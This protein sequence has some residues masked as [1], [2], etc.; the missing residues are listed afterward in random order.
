V[1]SENGA[2][3]SHRMIDLHV[4]EIKSE[5]RRNFLD[6]VWRQKICKSRSRM[7]LAREGLISLDATPVSVLQLLNAF[8]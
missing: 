6:F 4:C 8:M 5:S 3:V 1:D 7:L 2:K